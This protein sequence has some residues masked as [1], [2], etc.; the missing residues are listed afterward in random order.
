MGKMPIRRSNPDWGDHHNQT[1]PQV[2]DSGTA[3]RYGGWL[4][5]KSSTLAE[6]RAKWWCSSGRREVINGTVNPTKIPHVFYNWNIMLVSAALK[7]LATGW[8]PR[9]TILSTS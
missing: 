5:S 7:S 9:Q 1:R 6:Y 3:S 4:R 8:D 2:A